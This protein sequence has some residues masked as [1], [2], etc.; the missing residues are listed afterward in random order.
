MGNGNGN[1][2]GQWRWWL[3]LPMV[4]EMAMADGK[5]N[6]NGN[7]WRQRERD[8]GDDRLWRLQQQWLTAMPPPTAIGYGNV[9]SKATKTATV[10]AM[11]I[12]MATAT[13]TATMTKGGLPLHVPAMCSTVAGAIPCLHPHGHKGK[14]IHQRCI[15]GVTLLRVFAPFQGWEFLTAHH[16]LFFCFFLLLLFSLLNNPLFSPCIIQALKNPVSPVTLYLLHSSKN[17]I[18][19]LTIYP[20]SYCTFCWG[21]PGQG[22]QWL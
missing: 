18:S 22:L 19:L 15:I 13:A 2:D 4:T 21:K 5:G 20:S 3:R 17:P 1:G 6:G 10:T 8:G 12:A 11:A 16:G 14:C 7:G 9:D